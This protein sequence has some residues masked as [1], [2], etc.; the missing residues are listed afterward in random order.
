MNIFVTKLSDLFIPKNSPSD[1]ILI[2]NTG[3]SWYGFFTRHRKP[4]RTFW[5]LHNGMWYVKS[6][7]WKT[8]GRTVERKSAVTM[9][10]SVSLPWH[11]REGRWWCVPS[12]F[13]APRPAIHQEPLTACQS[14]P[15]VHFV[16]QR[17]AHIWAV[18]W[19]GNDL[20]WIRILLTR[21]FQI[22]AQN[23]AKKWTNF[24]L[25]RT[26]ADRFLKKFYR[27]ECYQR[28]MCQL[29]WFFK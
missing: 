8:P 4:K 13:P 28:R 29:L 12:R 26:T 10:C 14:G 5:H 3:L 24:K 27:T 1:R 7:Q 9:H 17:F 16:V 22:R 21:S 23:Q 15:T 25:H 2:H 6:A 20:V 19:I 18:L 11:C